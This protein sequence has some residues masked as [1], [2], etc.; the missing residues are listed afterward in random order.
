MLRKAVFFV[1]LFLFSC[2]TPGPSTSIVAESTPMNEEANPLASEAQIEDTSTQNTVLTE[3]SLNL[4]PPEDIIQEVGFFGGMGGGGSLCEFTDY[5]TP[6]FLSTA[7][8]PYEW[9]DPVSVEL[10]VLEIYED[11]QVVVTSPSGMTV[12]EEMVSPGLTESGTKG[13]IYYYYTPKVFDPTGEYTITFTGSNWTLEYYF[14]LI[15]PPGA[16]LYLDEEQLFL[17]NFSPN[18]VIRLLVYELSNFGQKFV[19]WR[20]FQVD[21]RGTLTLQLV[22]RD[23]YVVVGEISGQ[24]SVNLEPADVYCQG[25]REPVGLRPDYYAELLVDQLPSYVFDSDRQTWVRD[26]SISIPAGTLVRIT[27]NATCV[28]QTFVWNIA[29][30]D[31]SCDYPMVPESG[32]DGYYLR[33]LDELPATATPDPA[34]IP[35]CPGTQPTR[36]RVGMNAEVTTS[37]MAPQLSL[38]VEPGPNAEKVHV[39]AAGRDMVILDGPVCADHSY[40]WYIRSEQGFEGWAREGDNEDYWIDPLP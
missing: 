16:R 14:T 24:L 17:V 7:D 27:S 19:G 37:G 32:T 8:R 38:R 21:D 15:E 29:C 5:Q 20:K 40:W 10:C 39:I 18:E 3:D 13:V 30:L 36:L 11:V 23:S 31:K 33:P 2:A 25:A 35:T 9:M 1:S 4:V 26:G 22:S 28:D 12:S 34:D 6:T